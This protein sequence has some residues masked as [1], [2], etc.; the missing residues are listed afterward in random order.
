M[1]NCFKLLSGPRT[2]TVTQYPYSIFLKELSNKEIFINV[3]YEEGDV[4]HEMSKTK[5]MGNATFE[6]HLHYADMCLRFYIP[7]PDFTPLM[8]IESIIEGY[9]T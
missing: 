2:V 8:N 5:D 7:I 1:V 4:C 3:K 6:E 9:I